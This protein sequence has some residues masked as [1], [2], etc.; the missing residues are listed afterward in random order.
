[1]CPC[2]WCKPHNVRK[3]SG[4]DM[5]ST[6]FTPPHTPYSRQRHIFRHAIPEAPSVTVSCENIT[7]SPIVPYTWLRPI[8]PVTAHGVK[9]SRSF[10]SLTLL[11]SL[12]GAVIHNF[13]SD[14]IKHNLTCNSQSKWSPYTRRWNP[15]ETHHGFL[16]TGMQV[17]CMWFFWSIPPNLFF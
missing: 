2:G 10:P 6:N 13:T 8:E 12:L 17:L 15:H 16:E 11:L 5:I 9:T 14:R 3:N 7:P 1:M 4:V